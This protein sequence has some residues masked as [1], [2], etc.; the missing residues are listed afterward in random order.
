MKILLLILLLP[1]ALFSQKKTSYTTPYEKGNGNQTATYQEAMAFYQQLDNGFET[2]QMQE[3]GTTDAGLPLHI[4]V[5]DKDKGFNFSEIRKKK[6]ILLINNGIHPGEPDGIDATMMLLRDLATGKLQA[7]ENTVVVAIPVYNIGGMLNRGSYSRANQNGPE[8][9]GFRGNSRNYDLNRDFIKA[10]T[11]E[12]RSFAALFHKV[13]PDVFIDNHVSNGAD[14]QCIFTY[15]ATQHQRLGGQLGDFFKAEMMPAILTAMKAK[16]IEATPYVN[17]HGDT[18][19]SGFQQFMDY[20]RY[21]TGY[22]SLFNVPGSMPE[23]H[24]LKEYSKRVG[25]TYEYMVQTL[26]YLDDNYQKIKDLRANNLAEYMPGARYTLQWEVDSTKVTLLPFLGYEADYKVSSVTG[27]QRLYYDRTRPFNKVVKYFQEYVPKQQV[28][29]PEA[30]IIPQE[31]WQVAELLKINNIQLQVLDKDT[32]FEVE[33]YRITNY[34]TSSYPYEGHYPHNDTQV[35]AT[36]QKVLFQKGDYVVSTAQPG[37]KYLLETLE[38]QGVDS[39]FNWN[40]F[41]AILQQKEY[42]SAYVFEDTAAQLLKENRQLRAEFDDKKLNDKAF[43]W[44]TAAQLDWIY[45][46][47]PYYEKSHMQYPVYRRMAK[48]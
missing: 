37:V 30:Y 22:A 14:Y 42:Y 1:A 19:E 23:T 44:D 41:D 31:W 5:F 27:Q 7:P 39:F 11:R 47:S 43:A 24:M 28:V 2:I 25:V 40:F 3:M 6:A 16:G 9:Y 48:Q 18:P 20:G 12:A 10:D 29:I 15:I 32:T 46:H 4:V 35:A 26:D 13:Q 8:S 36:T 38:P 33:S 45:T 34:K 21:S 17:I